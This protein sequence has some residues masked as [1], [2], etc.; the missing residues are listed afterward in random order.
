MANY[1]DATLFVV[2]HNYTFKKQLAMVQSIYQDKKLPH[3]S[4]VINDV[5]A[6]I[7]YGSYQGY[8]NYGYG[9]YGYGYRSDLE[10]YFETDKPRRFRRLRRIFSK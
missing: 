1:A 10:Q 2:R 8:V 7:G 9:G 5:K 4:L 3:L 6:Q